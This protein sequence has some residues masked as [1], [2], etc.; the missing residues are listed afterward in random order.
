[1]ADSSDDI[2]AGFDEFNS[3][4][5]VENF[6]RDEG[7]QHAVKTTSHGRKPP[8]LGRNLNTAATRAAINTSVGRLQTGVN[9]RLTT[10]AGSNSGDGGRP[11]TSVRAAGYSSM[12]RRLSTTMGGGG[13]W[14]AG[15]MT[16]ESGPAPP[17]EV[18][19]EDSPEEKIKV[20]EKRVNQLIEESCILASRGEISSAFEKAK[21]A[22]RKERVLVRQREQLGVADQINLDLTYSVLFNLANRYTASG[23]YQEALNTYQAIVRN[24]MFAHAG[25]LK[26]NMGNIY[27][28]Q[29]NYIKAIKFYRMGLD[30]V[31]NTHKCMRIKIMQNIGITFVKLGQY[32]DAIT[33]FEHIMQEDPD[34]KTGFNL[35]LCY[36]M[37]GDRSKMKYAFQQLLRVDLH[38]D[39]EDRYLPH[40]DD[41]QYDLILEVIR[42]DELRM[43][44]KKRKAQAENFIKMAA[45]LI[46]PA[47]ESN[48]HAGYDW[49]IEQVKMSNFHELAHDLEIDKAVM[50]LKQRDFHQD[51]GKSLH[52]KA[53]ETL[54]SFE[55]K[56]TRVAS[57][58]ATNLSFLYFLEGDLAQADRYADQALAADRYNPAALVNKGN[59]L[60]QQQN[61][62][63]ARD[64]YSEALQ[65]DSSCVEALYNLGIVC[66]RTER[67]EEALD[68]F[69]KLHAVLRNSAPVVFQIMDIYEKVEDPTQAQEWAMQL[70]GL[71][72]SDPFLLQRLGDNYEQEGDKSQAFSYYYDSF[73]YFP[74]NFDVIEWLGAYYIE[75]QFCEKAIAYFERANL[76]QPNQTKWLLMIASCHRRS[77][78]YQQALETY[79]VM[80]KKFPDNIDCLRFLVRLSTDMGLPEAQEYSNRLK[81]AEKAKE[82]RE[83]RQLSASNR[84]GSFNVT[85]TGRTPGSRENS[86]SAS[87]G[88][89]SREGSAKRSFARGPLSRTSVTSLP[90][91]PEDSSESSRRSAQSTMNGKVDY[92]DPLGP[93]TERPRTAARSRPIQDEFADEEIDDNLLPE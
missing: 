33:S 41:K 3:R 85:S 92:V 82:A 17:L 44:E 39:D 83:Q 62:E 60:F 53:I 76:M 71:V 10:A 1:M 63:R 51:G 45:K 50:Y 46:A 56:D 36:F 18:R 64:C 80:H 61:Y 70:H 73:K 25:R 14:S 59:V 22:G 67:Y 88:G 37:I 43:Y 54:K 24:K 20:M 78:N 15:Q 68:A 47:I 4:A 84:R 55:R 75:S 26:V 49:C 35:I 93:A 81:R 79:K 42:N 89:D 30:Q 28:A 29:K 77:G 74:C 91:Q 87:S 9:L 8:V 90:R 6:L 32:A 48:F 7:F 5:D 65:D 31:P 19:S 69:F 57:T 52:S 40:N 12:G 13:N 34:T 23:M 11:M 86:A 16:A 21:E 66:K 2:Y 27:F 72:P 38:L 58:A